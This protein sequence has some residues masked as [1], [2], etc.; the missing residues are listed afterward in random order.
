MDR[1]EGDSFLEKGIEGEEVWK[2]VVWGRKVELIGRIE[3]GGLEERENR[4][5]ILEERENRQDSF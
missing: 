4:Q 2:R 1:L 3:K 5:D